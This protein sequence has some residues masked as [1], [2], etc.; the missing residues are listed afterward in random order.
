MTA[1]DRQVAAGIPAKE[2]P[3]KDQDNL[4]Y[5]QPAIKPA[6]SFKDNTRGSGPSLAFDFYLTDRN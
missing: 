3:L 1:L 4:Q 5:V 2:V 6:G